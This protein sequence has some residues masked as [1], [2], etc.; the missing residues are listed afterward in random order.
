M[1]FSYQ[2]KTLWQV[3]SWE[4]YEIFEN[5]IFYRTPPV[6]ASEGLHHGF[7]PGKFPDSGKLYQQLELEYLNQRR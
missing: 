2:K 3:L 1:F 6:A 7:F 4:Y 5:S